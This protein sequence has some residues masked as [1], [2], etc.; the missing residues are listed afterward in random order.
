MYTTLDIFTYCLRARK[1]NKNLFFLWETVL[2][3]YVAIVVHANYYLHIFQ[4]HSSVF[5]VFVGRYCTYEYCRGVG[6]IVR[7]DY[8]SNDDVGYYALGVFPI[9]NNKYMYLNILDRW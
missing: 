7:D 4:Q 9:E 6:G 3:L 8:F 2:K 5:Y 1:T